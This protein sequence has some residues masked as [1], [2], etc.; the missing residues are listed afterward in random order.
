MKLQITYLNKSPLRVDKFLATVAPGLTR[1]DVQRQI[2]AEKLMINGEVTGDSSHRLREGDQ[3]QFVYNIPDPLRP[4]RQKL[5]IKYENLDLLVV[6]K[7][8][9]MAVYLTSKQGEPALL[10]ILLARY[11]KLKNVGEKTRPGIV[12]RLDRD[13]SGLLLVAKNQKTYEYLKSLFA[14]RKIQKEYLA[15]VFGLLPK[16]GIIQKPLTKIGQSGQSRV[17]VDAAGKAAITEYWSLQYYNS[18]LPPLKLRGGEGALSNRPLDQYTLVRIKLHTGRTHQIRVHFSSERHP[19]M[20]DDLYGKPQSQKLR[21]FLKRQFLHASKLEFQLED[22]TRVE[23]NAELP[24]DLE[25]V[26]SQLNKISN[27]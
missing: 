8:A 15:L 14:G 21:K 2:A 7:P 22:G 19:I 1:S 3:I 11:P 5:V 25:K 16:H 6:E 26:L 20:G 13:T 9:G 4:F 23:V 17:R 27:F 24:E 10:N 18:P 12:H